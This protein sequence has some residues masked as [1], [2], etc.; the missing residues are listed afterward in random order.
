MIGRHTQEEP[1]SAV[2]ELLTI[3]VH[4]VKCQA[5]SVGPDRIQNTCAPMLFQGGLR[6]GRHV[7]ILERRN[8]IDIAV[9]SQ[10]FLNARHPVGQH[11]R[12]QE[13][14]DRIVQA[15][16]DLV[17]GKVGIEHVRQVAA[18][19]RGRDLLA[20]L[21]PG[22]Q[23]QID[24]VGRIF[25]FEA[26]NRILNPCVRPRASHGFVVGPE[27]PVR[28]RPIRDFGGLAKSGL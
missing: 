19:E 24:F 27:P 22:D 6:K 11:I 10:V 18:G 26:G 23:L 25:R 13:L 17:G 21:V 20:P 1:A 5:A 14:V 9:E 16:I 2:A 15:R 12:R 3:R 28:R 7:R 4:H 8:A